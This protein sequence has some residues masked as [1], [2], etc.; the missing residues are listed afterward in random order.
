[1]KTIYGI[2]NKDGVCVYVGQ[3]RNL[4]LRKRGHKHKNMGEFRVLDECEGG[5]AMKLEAFWIKKYAD[6]GQAELNLTIK[7]NHEIDKKIMSLVPADG[8]VV[9]ENERIRVLQLAKMMKMFKVIDFDV[10]TRIRPD[11]NFSVIA[12]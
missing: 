1:M 4:A 9:S 7:S 5:H 8:F 2:F 6:M 12:I 11:G 3:T 10:V